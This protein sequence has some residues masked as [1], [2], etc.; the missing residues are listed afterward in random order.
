M[1]VSVFVSPELRLLILRLREVDRET[2]KQIRRLTKADA[3]P[4]WQ[5]AVAEHITTRPEALVL[6]RTARV[7]V[8]D[9]NVTLTSARIGKP[10]K[11]GLDPKVD[12]HV[13]E[14]GADR[15]QKTTYEARSSRGRSFTVTRRTRAQLRARQPKGHVVYPAAAETIPRLA[16]LWWATAKRALAE[17]LEG[18]GS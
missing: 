15:D 8:S 17:A 12:Y 10:L 4:M 1:R 5:R 3:Q 9:Q 13:I 11:G 16:S 2:R 7:T 6:G 18:K 14:F